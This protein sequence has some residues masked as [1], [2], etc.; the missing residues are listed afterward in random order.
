MPQDNLRIA[1]IYRE[2]DE[3]VHDILLNI[4]STNFDTY[5]DIY[6]DGQTES[7]AVNQSDR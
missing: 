7:Q 2:I 3:A 4:W 5:E 1:K 6:A